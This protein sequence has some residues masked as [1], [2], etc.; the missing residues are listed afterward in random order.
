MEPVSPLRVA[1]YKGDKDLAASILAADPELE[2]DVFDAACV[3]R[4]ERLHSLLSSDPSLALIRS[5]DGFTALH[6]AVFFDQP[7]AAV[8]LLDA[9]ADVNAVADN[10]MKVQP[11][12]S[13]IAGHSRGGAVLL[14]F[15]GADVGA[16]QQ[17]GFTP[18]DAAVQNDDTALIEL[19]VARG[20]T[21]PA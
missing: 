19:L 13:A 9:G 14:I 5:G 6:F 18:M 8:L 3:G 16:E 7:E 1:L 17:G 21:R 2:L 4:V 20:A 12:H 10:E 11:L 15:A